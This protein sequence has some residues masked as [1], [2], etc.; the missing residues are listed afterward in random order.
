MYKQK[1]IG[2]NLEYITK[3]F[4]RVN[5]FLLKKLFVVLPV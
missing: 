3:C 1:N 2:V 4:E 5:K